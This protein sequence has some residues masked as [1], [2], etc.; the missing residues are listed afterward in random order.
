MR[1]YTSLLI[2]VLIH[3][4]LLFVTM[5]YRAMFLIH[6]INQVVHIKFI[7]IHHCHELM[8]YYEATCIND[9]HTL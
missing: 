6:Y 1:I 8:R 3:T 2:V 4:V 7:V 5:L 9:V